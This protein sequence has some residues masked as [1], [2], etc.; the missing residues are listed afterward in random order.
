MRYCNPR[1]P[2]ILT[3]IASMCAAFSSVSINRKYPS[4]FF[5]RTTGPLWST[6]KTDYQFLTSFFAEC[7][8]WS[9]SVCKAEWG[10][11][12]IPANGDH[13]TSSS[14]LFFTTTGIYN[15]F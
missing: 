2:I 8:A 12:T 7:D 5:Y 6:N 11:L 10:Q 9:E 14:I 1:L 4:Y 3:A 15:G 13:P